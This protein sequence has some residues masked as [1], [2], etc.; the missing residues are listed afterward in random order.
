VIESA[1]LALGAGGDGTTA[2]AVGEALAA[3]R[4]EV[5]ARK[6]E[7]EEAEKRKKE[8]EAKQAEEARKAAEAKAGGQPAAG[9]PT[10]QPGSPATQPA[11]RP[12]ASQPASQPAGPRKV[13][14]AVALLADVL[15]GQIPAFLE[16]AGPTGLLYLERALGKERF[17]L[18]LL[19]DGSMPSQPPISILA[20]K[21]KG[22][23]AAIVL[24][25]G[26]ASPPFRE[27]LINQAAT[28]RAAGVDVL[29]QPGLDQEL[30]SFR[31][32]LAQLVR[33]GWDA[34]EALAALTTRPARWLGVSERVGT[35][36]K[37]KD[38]DLLLFSGDFLDV[39]SRLVRVIL[40]GETVYE[41]GKD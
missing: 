10:A 20:G 23:D 13:P 16:V 28:F 35:I 5:E 39:Q 17:P 3:A 29:L 26:L 36:E 8:E 11:T 30:D 25:V 21:V 38:A 34:A 37:G 4:A 14:T 15:E 41:H 24:P 32:R 27:T 6:K 1:A 33:H 12:A 19:A 31:L 2:K 9:A 7:R 22:L 18:L 40:E